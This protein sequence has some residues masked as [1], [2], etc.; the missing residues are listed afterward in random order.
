M[1]NPWLNIPVADYEGH[2]QSPE[3]GQLQVLSDLFAAGLFEYVD[4]EKA[5]VNICKSLLPDGV[6][7]AA[8]QLPSAQSAPVTK[9]AFGSLATLG[10]IM[11]LVE[12]AEFTRVCA[13]H[14]MVLAREK[15]VPLKQGKAL[16]VGEYRLLAR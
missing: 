8:L 12:S 11:K 10:S 16:F 6:L 7:V 4:I 3:V 14:R 9:T 2:M 5:L 15:K 1:K 13:A